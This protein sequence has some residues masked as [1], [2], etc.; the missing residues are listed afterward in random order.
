[1]KY[2]L[3]GLIVLLVILHQDYWQWEDGRLVGGFLP[4]S[5]AYHVGISVAAAVVW[6]MATRCCWPEAATPTLGAHDED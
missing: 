3:G 2:V 6:W 5:L 1:M 4:I